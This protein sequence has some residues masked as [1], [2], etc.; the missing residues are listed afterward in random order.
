MTQSKEEVKDK[1]SIQ[2][3]TTLT[4]NSIWENNKNTRKHHTQESQEVSPFPAGDHKT[5]RNRQSKED[6]NDQK[7]I[8]PSTTPVQGYQIG[9]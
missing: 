3:N 6:S 4:E 5:A 2:S 9:K 7:S 1:E 8:Q